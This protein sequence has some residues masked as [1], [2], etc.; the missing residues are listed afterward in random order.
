MSRKGKKSLRRRNNL[1]LYWIITARKKWLTA[2][3]VLF[4]LATMVKLLEPFF[5]FAF[6]YLLIFDIDDKDR[7]FLYAVAGIYHLFSRNSRKAIFF[8]VWICAQLTFHLLMSAWVL[9]HHLIVLF[10]I[11]SM[12]AAYGLCTFI[13]RYRSNESRLLQRIQGKKAAFLAVILILCW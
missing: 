5:V 1:T 8:I 2:S 7:L 10:P 12:L 11:M 9:E 4:G 6:S 3:A 13:E